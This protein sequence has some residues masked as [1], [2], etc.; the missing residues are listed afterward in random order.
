MYE[1]QAQPFLSVAKTFDMITF[2][3]RQAMLDMGIPSYARPT[4]AL[5]EPLS[6]YVE[7]FAALCDQLG[8][9]ASAAS[10]R[11]LIRSF[12]DTLT[13]REVDLLIQQSYAV[14]ANQMMQWH[15]IALDKTEAELFANGLETEF[16]SGAAE[17]F[18]SLIED[19]AEACKCLSVG[20]GTA[21][22]FHLMRVLE[23]VVKAVWLSLDAAPTNSNLRGWGD[24]RKEIDLYLDGK[25]NSPRLPDWKQ[26]EPFYRDAH[27][28]LNTVYR[29]W[30]NP[31]MHLEKTYSPERAKDILA[32]TK[33][34]IKHVAE[35]LNEDGAYT[36]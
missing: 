35:H 27:A 23:G 6:K 19:M 20:R 5:L 26:R 1:S 10:A 33:T 9:D 36:P 29:A 31:T 25:N 13:T 18:P 2:S 16:G 34:L 17:K 24:Y 4:M 28:D 12:N 3:F 7:D 15:L 8:A 30:R 14:F 21:S 32:A 11:S 22:V